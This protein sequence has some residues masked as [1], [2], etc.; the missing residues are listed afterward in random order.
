MPSYIPLMLPE[1]AADWMESLSCCQ[2]SLAQHLAVCCTLLL[3]ALSA[4]R[5]F[6]LGECLYSARAAHF[7]SMT[8]II[9]LDLATNQSLCLEI[10]FPKVAKAVF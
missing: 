8:A 9:S 10:F 7:A 3:A 5:D 6:S 1:A 4:R 2:Y